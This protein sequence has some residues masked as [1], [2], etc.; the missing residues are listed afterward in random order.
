MRDPPFP[1]RNPEVDETPLA[2]PY[3]AFLE[4]EIEILIGQKGEPT[5][6]ESKNDICTEQKHDIDKCSDVKNHV[7]SFQLVRDSRQD[8]DHYKYSNRSTEGGL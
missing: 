6:Q 3:P 2:E 1:V 4:I 7:F 5:M 8:G